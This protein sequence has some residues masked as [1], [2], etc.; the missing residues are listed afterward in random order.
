[1]SAYQDFQNFFLLH[2]KE[3]LDGL[4]EQYFTVMTSDERAR[5]FD[6]LMARVELGGSEE[7]VFGLFRAD[8][9]RAIAP[10]R[11][12]LQAGTLNEDAQIAA[13]WNL[14][15]LAPDDNLLVVFVH[16]LKSPNAGLREKAAYWVPV[17]KFT[18]LLKLALQTM[19]ST[20]TEQLAR[21]H[22][23]DKLL[24]CYGV[25][26]ESVSKETYL[27]IYRNLHSDNLARKEDAFTQLEAMYVASEDR[28]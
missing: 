12:L 15:Q 18:N 2:N 9:Q 7:S 25:S 20:E 26:A 21:I 24:E 13:A 6:Y 16:F 4:S 23:V 5:A 17:S 22:A 1:M 8:S 28:G 14:W 11:R 27:K 10:I 3:R 19:I